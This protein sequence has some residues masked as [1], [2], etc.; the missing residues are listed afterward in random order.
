MTGQPDPQLVREI[1]R[2]AIRYITGDMTR[3]RLAQCAI[4]EHGVDEHDIRTWSA[5]YEAVIE[6][7]EAATVTVSWPDEQAQADPPNCS[8]CGQWDY[9]GYWADGQDGAWLCANCHAAPIA[10]A[11]GEPMQAERDACPH[12]PDGHK[13]P[14]RQPWSAWVTDA[15][16]GDGQPTTI[17]VARSNSAHVAESDAQWIRERLN[18]RTGSVHAERDMCTCGELVRACELRTELDRLRAKTKAE[19]DAEDRDEYVTELLAA[20]VAP[21]CEWDGRGNCASHGVLE[22]GVQCPHSLARAFL[23]GARLHT[24]ALAAERNADRS[25]PANGGAL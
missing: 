23:A 19:R 2:T 11:D 20:V 8:C 16:D 15:R 22:P 18:D 3:S 9:D 12:C 7:I 14:D 1:A 25:V 24:A 10:Y 4:A 21:A 17:H 5:C 6:A 13:C